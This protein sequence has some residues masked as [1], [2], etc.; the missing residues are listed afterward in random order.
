MIRTLFPIL[1]MAMMAQVTQPFAGY[2]VDRQQRLRPVF[3]IAG[4]F[5]LGDSIAEG[6]LSV[7]SAGKITLAKSQDEVWT[8]K[9][10]A[11]SERKPAPAGSA[12]FTFAAD[13]TPLLAVFAEAGTQWRWKDGEVIE[14]PLAYQPAR[15]DPVL[16]LPGSRIQIHLDTAPSRMDQMSAD[17]YLAYNDSGIFAIRVRDGKVY[18]LPE[19]LQ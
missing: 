2:C 14:E 6:V 11:I 7:A 18:Q 16:V 1:A 4:N 15:L 19:L 17:W 5:V 12:S 13:G 9:A 3:G 8:I 10:G